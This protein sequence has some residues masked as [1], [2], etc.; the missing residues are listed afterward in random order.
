M[1]YVKIRDRIS[2]NESR[3]PV[4]HEYVD[5]S[6]KTILEYSDECY[7]EKTW[8]SMN[9]NEQKKLIRY[10]FLL[11]KHGKPNEKLNPEERCEIFILIDWM[12]CEGIGLEILPIRKAHLK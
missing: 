8:Q 11:A 12:L 5:G 4:L 6:Q 9:P 10:D 3:V 7:S 2:Y 1:N